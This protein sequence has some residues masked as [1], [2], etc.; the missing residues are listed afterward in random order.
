[1]TTPAAVCEPVS[2]TSSGFGAGFLRQFRQSE[3][4][5]LDAPVFGDENIL[6]FQVAVDDPL[7]VRRRQPVRDL[8][9]ILDRL[10]LG[11]GAAIERR[12]QAFAL[13]QLG[14][15]KRRALVLTDVMNGENVGMV[16]RGHRPRLL[17]KAT[18]AVASR[19]KDSGRI[20][21]ATSRPR[22]VSFARYTSPM[23]PA[24]SGDRIS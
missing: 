20:F 1:M 19:A 9:S 14:D 12:A 22:R 18:Q 11:Q 7:F 3:I 17:L 10:T 15:Q 16:E 6:R 24:P 5:D 21:R 4:Q 8:H 13:Q 2:V 23:P